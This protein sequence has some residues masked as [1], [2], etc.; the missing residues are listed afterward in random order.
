M[1]AGGHERYVRGIR[2]GI[3]AAA[4]VKAAATLCALGLDGMRLITTPDETESLV[5]Q[6][7]AQNT[8]EVLQARDKALAAEIAN[9]VGRL[10]R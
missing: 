3:R 2:G 6:A 7:V 1:D 9:A 8:L 4:V 10:F 5:M